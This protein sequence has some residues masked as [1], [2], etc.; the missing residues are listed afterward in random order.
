MIISMRDNE[1]S[2]QGLIDLISCVKRD[3]IKMIEVGSYA[4]ASADIFAS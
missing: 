2:R 3:N 4:G 1:L